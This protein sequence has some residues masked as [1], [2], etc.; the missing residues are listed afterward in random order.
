M[1]SIGGNLVRIDGKHGSYDRKV[2]NVDVRYGRNANDNYKS[3]IADLGDYTKQIPLNFE[4]RYMPDGRFNKMALLGSAYEELGKRTRVKTDDLNEQ[5][6]K[7]GLSDYTANA[8]DVDMDGYVD[9]GEYAASTLVQDILSS[10]EDYDINPRKVNGVITPKGEQRAF[11][12][13]NKHIESQARLVYAQLRNEF[14][15]GQAQKEFLSD[16]NNLVK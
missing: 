1:Y 8:L 10:G 11:A 7:S 13:N 5:L 12:L 16:S 3:Y 15:L 4:Y 14:K 2:L 9:V 6:N